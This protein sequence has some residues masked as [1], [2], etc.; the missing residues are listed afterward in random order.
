VRTIQTGYW[1]GSCPGYHGSIQS[2]GLGI[3]WIINS[4]KNLKLPKGLFEGPSSNYVFWLPFWYLQT[5][6]PTHTYLFWRFTVATMTWFS[7]RDYLCH[8][9]RRIYSDC[10]VPAPLVTPVVALKYTHPVL[11][12]GRQYYRYLYCHNIAWWM[13]LHK[14]VIRSK[15]YIN[16]FS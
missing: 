4:N 7:I 12:N 10:A 3:L 9:W 5:L 2:L 13:L 1:L 6:L 15:L 8:N 14:F 11:H 16:F